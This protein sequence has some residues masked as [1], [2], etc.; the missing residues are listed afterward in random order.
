[1]A[2]IMT[3]ISIEAF[4]TVMSVLAMVTLNVFY[5]P[6]VSTVFFSQ[7]RSQ[8]HPF[9]GARS[10]KNSRSTILCEFSVI[11]LKNPLDI[12]KKIG[13]LC[14]ESLHYLS[15]AGSMY[16][17]GSYSRTVGVYN[18]TGSLLYLLAGHRGGVTQVASFDSLKIILLLRRKFG[19]FYFI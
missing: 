5:F 6:L 7:T 19:T 13:L 8:I 3:V 1:M 10:G 16:A 17:A 9:I 15:P 4:M 18:R 12:G 2:L 11:R 14:I